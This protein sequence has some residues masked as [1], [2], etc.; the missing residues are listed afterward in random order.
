MGHLYYAPYKDPHWWQRSR[1]Y[2]LHR[3]RRAERRA[4]R[5]GWVTLGITT[6]EVDAET[7]WPI[8]WK[9]EER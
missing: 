5:D 6:G 2:M 3:I 8:V 7:G 9:P 1:W 4:R